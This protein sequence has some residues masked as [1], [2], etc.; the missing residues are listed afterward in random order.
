MTTY[1]ALLRGVNVGGNVLKME[2]LRELCDQIG[3]KNIRTYVQSGNVV[4]NATGTPTKLARGL[5]RKLVG[6]SRLP[7][8]VILISQGELKAV[9]AGNPFAKRRGVDLSRLHVTF[10]DAAGEPGAASALGSL[11]CGDDEFHHKGNSLYLY[12]PNG[13]ARS[14]LVNSRLERAFGVKCTT[15]NWNT[16]NALFRI[17]SG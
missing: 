15:R 14:K 5:E 2:R 12:C 11:D 9:I 16:V 4:F 6:Q 3:F 17:A 10:L 7:V 1:I 8:S 13:Y